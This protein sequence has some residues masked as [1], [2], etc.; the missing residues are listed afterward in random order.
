MDSGEGKSEIDRLSAEIERHNQLYY[1]EGESEI[2]DR[3]Y[4]EMFRNLELLEERFPEHASPNSPTKR[5]GGAP[6]DGF[7]QRLHEVPMLSIDD[8]FSE[9]EL[10]DF[11]TRLRKNLATELV[12][13]TIEPKIDGVAV[14]LHYRNGEL[15]YAVTRGDGTLG[16]VITENVKT[17]RSIPLTLPA[18]AP[19]WLEVRGEIFMST[20]R[21]AKM[22]EQR[23][24]QGLPVFK[25]PRNATAG[26]LK[27]LDSREVAKRPLDF[28]AHGLGGYE[29]DPIASV[30]DFHSVLKKNGIPVNHPVWEAVDFEGAVSAVRELDQVRHDLPYGTD[31]AVI[32]VN[33]I[34]DQVRLGAT[35]R[36][37]RW[38]AAFKYPPEQVETVLRDITVQVGRTGSMTPV[39]ELDPV[40]VSGTT[41][42]RAT[43]HNQD[44]IDRKDVRIGDTVLIEKAGEIIPAVVKVIL[45]KRP[46][47]ARAYNLFDS[48]DGKCPSCWSPIVKPEGVVAWK[49]RNPACPAKAAN[50]VKQFVSR[51]ALDIDGIG[52]IVA[53]KLVEREMVISPLDL[54]DLD[55]AQLAPMNLGTEDEPRILGPKNAARIVAALEKAKSAPLHRWL[56][57]MGISQVGESAARELARLHR[58]FDEIASSEILQELR[59]FQAGQRKE[60]ND[61]LAPY[62]IASEVGPAVAGSVL[63]FF[64]LPVGETFLQRLKELNLNPTSANYAPTRAV[65]EGAAAGE[66]AGKTFVITGTLSAPRGDFK[67]RILALGG[68]VAGSISGKTD[69]LLAGENAGS[70]LTK[71]E[72]L[73]VAVLN[74]EEFEALA[75]ST[76]PEETGEPGTLFDL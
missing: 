50:Q 55:E 2:S 42:K 28:I 29:G 56:F 21:F 18:G 6:I 48:I 71:A 74:E 64:V 33:S 63:D 17:I 66:V 75:G 15:D 41:V 3:D 69:Y 72:S 76:A 22:N 26:A 49:C 38:A 12:P 39:A 36:A 46:A 10:S 30:Q 70:K 61:T 45:E 4:D 52:S 35:S 31:G 20:E 73:G 27:L 54:F 57:G 58:N 23:Q 34:A 60:D 19:A 65:P 43:L 59:T 53:E 7:Q 1:V 68:K 44:E 9:D 40:L 16:D 67:E 14:A 51:K 11:F 8:V 25:N 13:V 24:E 62:E 37:P 5:V 32:K 47:D